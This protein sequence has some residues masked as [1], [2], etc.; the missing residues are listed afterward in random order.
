M[1]SKDKT[2]ALIL[3]VIYLLILLATCIGVWSNQGQII[4]PE[5]TPTQTI[6]PTATP[7]PTATPTVEPTATPTAQPTPTP[8][9]VVVPTPEEAWLEAAYLNEL[10]GRSDI[11][12]GYDLTQG[13]DPDAWYPVEQMG[14]YAFKLT[15]AYSVNDDQWRWDGGAFTG[16]TVGMIAGD[17]NYVLVRGFVANVEATAIFNCYGIGTENRT[18]IETI[19]IHLAVRAVATDIPIADYSLPPKS[20]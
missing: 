6:E 4:L 15:P 9:P 7:G 2:I 18:N 19:S 13:A 5:P 17:D 3:S 16:G 1:T 10:L 12:G 20:E 11:K 8:T 14:W